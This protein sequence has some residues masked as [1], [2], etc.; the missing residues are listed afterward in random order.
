ALTY[1]VDSWSNATTP[2]QVRLHK[3]DGTELRTIDDN[4][5]PAFAQYRLSKPEFLQVKT[6][7]GFVMEAM[8]IKP[9][10]FNPSRRY[11][12]YQFTYGGPHIQSVK[13]SWGGS[14]YMYHQLLAQN[15]IIVWICD[16]RTAS[17]KGSESVWR[18]F[19]HFGDSEL[20]DIEDGV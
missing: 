9:P 14:Q 1:Y 7:D 12:V 11:P 2:T 17:G 8:M 16:N 6:R 20:R 5:V 13:N 10:D 4:K 3:N 15:G 18:L 19:K